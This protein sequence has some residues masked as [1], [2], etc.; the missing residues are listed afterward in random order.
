MNTIMEYTEYKD[1]VKNAR[2]QINKERKAIETEEELVEKCLFV[3]DRMEE[4]IT[5]NEKLLE[6]QELLQQELE[7]ERKKNAELMMKMAGQ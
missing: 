5:E 4:L 2:H 6:Q 1:M 3:F 7:E